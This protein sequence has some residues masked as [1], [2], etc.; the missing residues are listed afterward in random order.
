MGPHKGEAY[1]VRAMVMIQKSHLDS[2]NTYINLAMALE[3]ENPHFINNRGYVR[4][5][6]GHLDE[7]L[8]DINTSISMDRD[9]AWA[10]RNKGIYHKILGNNREALRLLSQS[11]N[12]DSFVEDAHYLTFMIGIIVS[13]TIPELLIM[14]I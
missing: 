8:V 9:N 10:I 1:N 5:L 11:L 14:K 7:A 12:M 4:L 6:L 13:P 2:A 3:P